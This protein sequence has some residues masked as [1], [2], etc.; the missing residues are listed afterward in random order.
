MISGSGLKSRSGIIIG[1]GLNKLNSNQYGEARACRY[2]TF[3]FR[4]EFNL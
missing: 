4:D 2:C 1:C 3:A